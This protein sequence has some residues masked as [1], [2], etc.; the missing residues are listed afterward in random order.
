MRRWLGALSLDGV[1]ASPG[2]AKAKNTHIAIA[3]EIA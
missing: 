3:M 2:E 1:R